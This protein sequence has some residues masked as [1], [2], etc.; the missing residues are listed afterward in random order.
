VKSVLSYHYENWHPDESRDYQVVEKSSIWPGMYAYQNTVQ[1]SGLQGDED[2]IIGLVNSNNQ[3]P[4]QEISMND[5]WQVLLTHDIQTY[6]RQWWLGLALIVPRNLY[7]GYTEAPKSGKLSNSFLAKLKIENNK[8]VTYYTAA[9]W[10]MSDERFKDPEFFS[11]YIENLVKQL[12]AKVE[13]T[14][15]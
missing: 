8:P 5:Q 3:N 14:I 6:D 7:L 10:E 2:M 15:K 1:F 13:V 12:S 4:L 9:G 11:S